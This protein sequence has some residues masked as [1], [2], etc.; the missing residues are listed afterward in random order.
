MNALAI[1]IQELRGI[2]ADLQAENVRPMHIDQQPQLPESRV[3]RPMI[4]SIPKDKQEGMHALFER[5]LNADGREQWRCKVVRKGRIAHTQWYSKPSM[6]LCNI[7]RAPRQG[8]FSRRP[9]YYM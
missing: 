6:I 3:W 5:V 1:I 7:K 8:A 2:R 9:S 4:W